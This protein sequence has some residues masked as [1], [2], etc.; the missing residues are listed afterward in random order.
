[1]RD[2]LLWDQSKSIAPKRRSYKSV[3]AAK[4]GWEWNRK[5]ESGL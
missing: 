3:G 4:V 1:M 5:D 2:A